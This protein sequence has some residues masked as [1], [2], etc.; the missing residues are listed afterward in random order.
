M[1]NKVGG[2]TSN[3]L[4]VGGE[5]NTI[6]IATTYDG[7][8]GRFGVSQGGNSVVV[9]STKSEI[10]TSDNVLSMGTTNSSFSNKTENV[11]AIGGQVIAQAAKNSIAF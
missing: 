7:I 2:P 8:A 5:S 11:A 6:N 9:G 3:N 10:R 1:A 4:I